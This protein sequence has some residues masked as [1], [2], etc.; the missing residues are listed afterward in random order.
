MKGLGGYFKDV[1]QTQ[2]IVSLFVQGAGH[3]ARA[4]EMSSGREQKVLISSAVNSS[5]IE[6]LAANCVIDLN[7]F[8]LCQIT[9]W[10]TSASRMAVEC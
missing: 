8:S 9:M 3:E 1:M 4:E 2:A 5:H 10:I 6:A 7:S